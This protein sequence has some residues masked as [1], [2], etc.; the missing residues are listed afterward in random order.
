[1]GGGFVAGLI[2]IGVLRLFGG[3]SPLGGLVQQSPTSAF[4]CL[5]SDFPV[6]PG[7]SFFNQAVGLNPGATPGNVC[8]KTFHSGDPPDTVYAFFA[9]Q[10]NAGDWKV[11]SS[12]PATRKIT[13]ISAKH[14]RTNG[15]VAI[16][17]GAGFTQILIY[18]YVY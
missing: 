18:F 11:Q 6:Y 14:A 3:T 9:A 5:P 12:N 10:L 8:E 15:N 2:I 16:T 1:M 13:F 7:E 4:A 17:R